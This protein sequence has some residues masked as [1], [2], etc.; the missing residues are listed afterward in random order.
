MMSRGQQFRLE[1]LRKCL[2]SPDCV[3][4]NEEYLR[5]LLTEIATEL[6]RRARQDRP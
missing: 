4:R 2:A 1:L 3:A 6:A 5:A